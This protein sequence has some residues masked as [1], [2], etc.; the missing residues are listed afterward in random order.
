MI[1]RIV[2]QAVMTTDWV[3]HG[4]ITTCRAGILDASSSKDPR[5][6]WIKLKS[7]GKT[8]ELLRKYTSKGDQLIIDGRLDME[9]FEGKDGKKKYEYSI[10]IDKVTW[11]NQKS[12]KQET[13]GGNNEQDVP[14]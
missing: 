8:A 7:F 11:F 1:N 2:C 3:D 9:V 4:K 12:K 5:N 10:I 14:F 13:I 6:V